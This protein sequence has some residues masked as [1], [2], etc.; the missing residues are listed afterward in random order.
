MTTLYIKRASYSKDSTPEVDREYQLAG[1]GG[2]APVG[3]LA[4]WKQYASDNG[5]DGVQIVTAGR[6]GLNVSI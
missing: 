4:D 2:F 5:Y 6:F 3:T 1:A